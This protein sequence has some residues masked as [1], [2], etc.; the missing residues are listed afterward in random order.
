MIHTWILNFTFTTIL[1]FTTANDDS[2][3]IKHAYQSIG[4][5]FPYTEI[6][7]IDPLTEKVVDL[8]VD[9]ELCIRGPNIISS[10]YNDPEKSAKSIDKNG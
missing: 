4:R 8:G 3:S 6:K 7:I 1:A 5:P 10:Y 9:G 2:K